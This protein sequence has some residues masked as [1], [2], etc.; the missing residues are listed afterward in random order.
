MTRSEEPFFSILTP[1]YNRATLLVDVFQSLVRQRFASFEWVIIDDGSTDGTAA[2]VESWIDTE[3]DFEIKY[4]YKNNGGKKSAVD[5][6]VPHLSGKLVIFLDSDDYLIDGALSRLKNFWLGF[7]SE[8]RDSVF[9]FFCCLMSVDG[10]RVGGGVR[11]L[12]CTPP[13]DQ[14][15]ERKKGDRLPV[16]KREL[17]SLYRFPAFEG[18]KFVPEAYLWNELSLKYSCAFYSEPV[19]ICRYQ[20]DGL[21]S[22]SISLRR[23]NPKG[24]LLYYSKASSVRFGLWNSFRAC[25][26]F[27]RFYFHSRVSSELPKH[28]LRLLGLA[29]GWLIFVKDKYIL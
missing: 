3:P 22:N 20:A 4:I 18:E 13:Q 28:P 19:C 9:G 23:N 1:S 15:D 2:L 26:N 27:Y 6:G 24:V 17:L 25:V 16:I 14:Y 5:F 10:K 7:S 12:L 11:F 29:L 21:S 8:T